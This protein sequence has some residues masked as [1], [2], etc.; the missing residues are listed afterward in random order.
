MLRV[1]IA[2]QANVDLGLAFV[3]EFERSLEVLVAHR[4]LLASI[5]ASRWL[6]PQR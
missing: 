3:T 6:A 5:G 1:S 4:F 2:E